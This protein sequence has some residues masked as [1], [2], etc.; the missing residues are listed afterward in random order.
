[1]NLLIFQNPW[2]VSIFF[3]FSKYL[4]LKKI[5]AITVQLLVQSPWKFLCVT[6]NL[7]TKIYLKFVPLRSFFKIFKNVKKIEKFQ[8]NSKKSINAFKI[9]EENYWWENYF[10]WQFFTNFSVL[11]CIMFLTYLIWLIFFR[12]MLYRE[13]L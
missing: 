11:L 5:E 2:I 4:F 8:I 7:R 12:F 3:R 1:M 9:K 13:V 6:W 10:F